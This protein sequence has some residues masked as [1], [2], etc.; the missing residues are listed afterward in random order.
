MMHSLKLKFVVASLVLGSLASPLGAIAL[1]ISRTD[2]IPSR[3]VDYGDLDL[4]RKSG[5]S[6]LYARI[7]SAAREVCEP[8]DV[9]SSKLLRNTFECRREAIARAVGDVNSESLTNYFAERSKPYGADAA[10]P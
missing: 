2:D 7:N 1:T 5:I 8:L 3:V 6:T 4:T 9:W 10:R